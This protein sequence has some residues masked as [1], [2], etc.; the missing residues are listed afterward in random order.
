MESRTGILAV[1]FYKYSKRNIQKE[2]SGDAC[3][4]IGEEFNVKL[5]KTKVSQCFAW[6]KTLS[7]IHIPQYQMICPCQCTALLSDTYLYYVCDNS[8][9]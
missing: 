9:Y 8:F 5:L 6:F 2:K 3:S 1:S 7:H 4:K